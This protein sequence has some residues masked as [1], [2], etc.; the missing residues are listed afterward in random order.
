MG[1]DYQ[2]LIDQYYSKNNP[3]KTVLKWALLSASV[4]VFFVIVMIA[5][6]LISQPISEWIRTFYQTKKGWIIAAL[7]I[8]LLT[9]GGKLMEVY[10]L[11]TKKLNDYQKTL[12]YYQKTIEP[13]MNHQTIVSYPVIE[14]FTVDGTVIHKN[15]P[16]YFWKEAETF[17][18][19]EQPPLMIHDDE[20]F[21]LSFPMELIKS[22]ELF[23][24]KL[25][26]NETYESCLKTRLSISSSFYQSVE[27]IF[28]HYF[29][30]VLDQHYIQNIPNINHQYANSR[31][32]L[33]MKIRSHLLLSVRMNELD[34]RLNN[35][36]I[37]QIEYDE[38]KRELLR[39][40]IQ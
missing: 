34:E 5:L 31:N 6:S 15:L 27:F 33:K 18:F 26:M 20:Y 22:I 3:K 36:L 24:E 1:I 23:E 10:E 19:L 8:A 13:V 25:V 7:V 40:S 16:I 2:A 12:A 30:A 11:T 4:I 9:L 29:Y 28:D 37:S 17:V 21:Y 32:N 39:D 35:G 38:Q 14:R